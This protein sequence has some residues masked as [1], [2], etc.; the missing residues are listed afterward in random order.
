MELGKRLGIGSQE[1][2]SPKPP[3]R[4]KIGRA[5]PIALHKVAYAWAPRPSSVIRGA[6]GVLA[7]PMK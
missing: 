6:H 5:L 3:V 7:L 1:G 4:S 2:V